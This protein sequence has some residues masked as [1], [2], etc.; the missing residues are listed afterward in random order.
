MSK[1][2]GKLN[3]LA[4]VLMD[5]IQTAVEEAIG[6]TGKATTTTKTDAKTSPAAEK[7]ALAE[8]KVEAKQ[9][10]GQ[11]LKG[12]GKDVLAELL[13]AAGAKTFP[14]LKDTAMVQ[15][16]MDSAT[17]ALKPKEDDLL[18]DAD[19]DLLGGGDPEPVVEKT[20]DDVKA[21]LLK[22]NNHKKLGREV[23]TE[24]LVELG[25]ERLP[26]LKK[27][28]FNEACAAAEEALKNA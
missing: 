15:A 17:E 1:L 2:E 6:A 3:A 18:G 25:V 8:L 10:A 23:T 19:D 12:P 24:I 9:I 28:K 14:G 5:V 4:V 22:I 20:R 21:L 16:F 13:K 7:K 11:V 26:Q 27:E